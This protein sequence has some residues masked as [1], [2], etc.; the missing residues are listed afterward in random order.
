MSNPFTC[1]AEGYYGRFGGA[2]IPDSLTANI[3]ALNAK[4]EE[5]AKSEP[6]QKEFRE[7]LRNYVGRPS[8]LYFSK[9]LSNQ[10]GR[11]I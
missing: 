6:F 1:N 5:I 10:Y 7:L 2:Y 9:S 3:E 8:P 4:Y 11:R